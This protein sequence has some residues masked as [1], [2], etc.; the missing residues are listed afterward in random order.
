ME[1]PFSMPLDEAMRSQRAMR[2]LQPDP[3]DDELLLQLVDLA[4]RAPSG[5]NAQNWHFVFL[6]DRSKLARLATLN[7]RGA[8]LYR[9]LNR[10]Q[11]SPMARSF[12]HQA[13]HFKEIPVVMVAC[14]RG[15]Y[16][17]GPLLY[18]ASFFASIFPAVQNFLLAARAAG[19]GT[20]LITI[21]LWN[22]WALSR[23]LELPWGVVPCALV[24]LGWPAREFGTNRRQPA[25]HSFHL[26]RFGHQPFLE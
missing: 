5:R 3:V 20:T 10:D 12:L 8:C 4:I 25:G 13:E 17:P 16:L 2:Y 7:R 6:K 1:N 22:S 15:W 23:L 9:W 18:S 11:S 24:P 14:Q 21:P 26:D 19:L